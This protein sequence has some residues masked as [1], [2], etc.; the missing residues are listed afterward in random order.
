MRARPRD[1]TGPSASPIAR[2]A[3]GAGAAKLYRAIRA[4]LQAAADRLDV[5]AASDGRKRVRALK[6][7]RAA[8]TAV[9]RKAAAVSKSRKPA[10]QISTSCAGEIEGSVGAI[11]AS[12]P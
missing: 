3:C 12:V 5:A 7:A 1:P 9:A 10:K 4:R 6:K 8:L 11:E 2:D